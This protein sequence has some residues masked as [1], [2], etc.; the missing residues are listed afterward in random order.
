VPVYD[1]EA[2]KVGVIGGVGCDHRKAV[3]AGDGGDLAVG[4][5]RRPAH[6]SQ[7][8]AFGGVPPGGL[9]VVGQYGDRRLHNLLHIPTDGLSPLRRWQPMVAEKQLV[10][11][12]GSS[13]HLVTVLPQP[14]K[15]S[16]VGRRPQGFGQDV[17]VQ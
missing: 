12:Y 4:E 10:P 2:P 17:G 6:R 8:R 9:R 16:M 3:D 14:F 7:S 1:F 5:R 13:G 11:D 15:D